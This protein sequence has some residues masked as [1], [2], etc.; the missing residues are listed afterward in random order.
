MSKDNDISEPTDAK[1]MHWQAAIFDMR[2]VSA[3][4]REGTTTR[5]D[6]QGP[7]ER[8]PY[9]VI[10]HDALINALHIPP[11]AGPY[12]EALERICAESPTTGVVGSTTTPAGTRSWP[13]STSGSPRSIPTTSCTK[14]KEKFGTLRYYCAPNGDPSTELDRDATAGDG[15]E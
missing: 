15:V 5:E 12:T 13:S 9:D 14:S 10:D 3:R 11:D 7:L 8:L 2:D 1:K 4:V 6:M